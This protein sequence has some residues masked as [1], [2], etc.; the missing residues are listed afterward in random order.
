MRHEIAQLLYL[1]ILTGLVIFKTS[2]L[3]V[4]LLISF[5]CALL[6]ACKSNP[7]FGE[8]LAVAA[9]LVE[10]PCQTPRR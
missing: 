2:P 1:A 4:T 7:L 6:T 10:S 5:C 8:A 9:W 3:V